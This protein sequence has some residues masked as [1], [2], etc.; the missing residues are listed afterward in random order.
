MEKNLKVFQPLLLSSNSLKEHVKKNNT[1]T[2]NYVQ[3]VTKTDT[4]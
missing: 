1:P 2:E 4:A 3:D